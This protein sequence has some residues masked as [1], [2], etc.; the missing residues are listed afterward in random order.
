MR[1]NNLR[2]IY[3]LYTII[4]GELFAAAI[5]ISAG[6]ITGGVWADILRIAGIAAIFIVPVSVYWLYRLRGKDNA[7]SSDE[8]EQMVLQK[9]FALAGVVAVSLLPILLLL[10]F[11]F[12]SAAGYIV[13]VYAGAV[14]G[15]MKIGA[16]YYNRKY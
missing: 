9:A 15:C 8:L 12:S 7:D 13:F 11:M 4:I 1:K 5:I 6:Y 2:K 16:Y 10:C 14:G 3:M